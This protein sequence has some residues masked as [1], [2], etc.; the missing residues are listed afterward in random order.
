MTLLWCGEEPIGIC[1]FNTAP[2]TL[3]MRNKFFG[4]SGKWNRL[5]MQALNRQ[6]IILSRVVIHPAYRGAGIASKFVR[7]SCELSGSPWI[8]TLAQMGH[9][10]PFFER[11]GFVKVGTVNTKQ[12]SRHSHSKLYGNRQNYAEEKGLISQETFNKSRHANPIYYIF[13]NRQACQKESR[14]KESLPQEES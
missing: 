12:R 5:A 6:L 10:N 2:K 1:V 13:D 9:L 11:A 14:D 8:E 3:S 4:R 7:R